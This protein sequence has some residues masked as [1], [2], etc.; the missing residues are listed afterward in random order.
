MKKR[1]CRVL[2]AVLLL[3]LLLP[4]VLGAISAKMKFQLQKI[5]F[6][7]EKQEISDIKQ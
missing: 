4:P 3:G 2:T 6:I 1:I 5:S 7:V